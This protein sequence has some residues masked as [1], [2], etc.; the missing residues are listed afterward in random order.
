MAEQFVKRVVFEAKR[1]A[2]HEN[3]NH[4]NVTALFCIAKQIQKQNQD[5]VAEK[6]VKDDNKLAFSATAKKTLC[7]QHYQRLISV[8]FPWDETQL[9]SVEPTAGPPTNTTNHMVLLSIQKMELR[10]PPGP[11]SP[12]LIDDLI[13]AIVK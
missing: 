7:R 5:I 3:F 4:K 2:L 8:Q 6:C 9:S 1:K 11:P 10:K 12:S 13:N